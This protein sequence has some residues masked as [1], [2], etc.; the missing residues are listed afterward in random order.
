LRHVLW[1]AAAVSTL[2]AAGASLRAPAWPVAFAPAAPPLPCIGHE[3]FRLDTFHV[4]RPRFAHAVSAVL[5]R[6]GRMRAVWYEGSRELAPDVRIWT[7]TFD[8]EAWG[9]PAAIIGAAE[10]SSAIG[11]YTRKLGNSLVYRGAGGDLVLIYAGAIGGWATVSLNV[12]R[13]R[14]EG[15]TWSPPRHLTTSPIFNLGNNVRGPA[16][17]TVDGLTLLPASYEFLR[18]HPELLLLDRDERVIGRQRIAT[19]FAGSQPFVAVL[20]DRR[21][22]SFSRVKLEGYTIVS[23]TD[24]VGWSWTRPRQSALRNYDKPVSVARLGGK[25]LLMVHNGAAPGERDV[26]RTLMLSVS[27]DEGES[28]RPFHYLERE[29][30]R[31]A[32]YPWLMAGPGGL[33]HL[34]FT[35]SDSAGSDLI[36]VRFSRDWIAARGGPA[37]P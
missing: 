19:E 20:D 26:D 2:L 13:S 5:L 24:D 18:S 32:H 25:H 28:W 33:Y 1:L 8:G 3:L 23:M 6:D 7:A 35:S 15:A 22:K 16:V 4:A 27:D 11:R 34:L 14:D 31:R 17:Q 12:M 36:H 30:G 21:A 9:T 10:T 37:C 29:Q